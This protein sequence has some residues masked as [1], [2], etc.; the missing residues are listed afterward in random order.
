ML[1][2]RREHR[3]GV[4]VSLGGRYEHRYQSVLE[5]SGGGKELTQKC[6]WVATP[7]LVSG[8]SDE[9]L[10]AAG[11]SAAV[12]RTGVGQSDELLSAAGGSEKAIQTGVG[13]E[14]QL[15]MKR[16]VS[17]CSPPK[18]PLAVACSNS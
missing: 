9:L 13:H 10:S 6:Y 3:S 18:M 12:I 5:K 8:E 14:G 1:E 2:Q 7:C 17:T 15:Y 4:R 16:A 11:G